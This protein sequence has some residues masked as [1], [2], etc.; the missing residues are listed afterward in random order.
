MVGKTQI[1]QVDGRRQF[2]LGIPYNDLQ[3][4]VLADRGRSELVAEVVLQ[5]HR[6]VL[7][8]RDLALQV[9]GKTAFSSYVLH[10]STSSAVCTIVVQVRCAYNLNSSVVYQA[11]E[12][13]GQPPLTHQV[14]CRLV[15]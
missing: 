11:M 15:G 9:G 7:T 3:C 6:A 4:D 8:G 14:G 12:L 2:S 13:G 5:H 10:N 1:L